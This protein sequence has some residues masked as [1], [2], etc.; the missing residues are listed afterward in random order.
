MAKES[1]PPPWSLAELRQKL[2]QS[3]GV[4]SMYMHI[5]QTISNALEADGRQDLLSLLQMRLLPVLV[6]SR[7]QLTLQEL[8]WAAGG[9]DEQEVS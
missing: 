9:A 8:A 3:T 2:P 7:E 1:A 5:L 6:A 4:A